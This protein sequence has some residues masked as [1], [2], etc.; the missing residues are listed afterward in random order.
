MSS[1]YVNL[2]FVQSDELILAL[3]F[4]VAVTITKFKAACV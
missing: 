3:C 1:E 2:S 4:A